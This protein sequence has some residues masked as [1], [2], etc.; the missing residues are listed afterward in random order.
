MQELLTRKHAEEL[1][2]IRPR[3]EQNASGVDHA[4]KNADLS[5]DSIVGF[6]ID[7]SVEGFALGGDCTVYTTGESFLLDSIR[8]TYAL[9]SESLTSVPQL[10]SGDIVRMDNSGF[11]AMQTYHRHQV[12][13][14]GQGY[15]VWNQFRQPDGSPMYPQRPLLI[16]PLFTQS[17]GCAQTGDIHG[18]M[19]LLP[20][21]LDREAFPWQADWYCRRVANPENVRLWYTDNALHADEDIQED[22]LHTVSYL[23]ALQEALLQLSDWVEKDA[24]PSNTSAYDVH[25]GQVTLSADADEHT[26]GGVQARVELTVNGG[27]KK[28]CLCASG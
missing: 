8:G 25:D 22:P 2:L 12:P 24:P 19:I 14:A 21:I 27:G 6:V 16:G 18:K 20:S 1:G 11:L 4:F 28:I 7:Q 23:G 5:D 17:T 13:E 9:L 10:K 26:C 15:D 3:T